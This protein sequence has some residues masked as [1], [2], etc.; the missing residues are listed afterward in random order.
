MGYILLQPEDNHAG[1]I[2]LAKLRSTGECSFD[3]T[4]GGPGLRPIVFNSRTC[5]ET[6]SHYHGF[7]G[8]IACVRRAIAKEKRHL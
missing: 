1:T 8:E 3:L 2:A 7:V 5:T 4:T 6:E